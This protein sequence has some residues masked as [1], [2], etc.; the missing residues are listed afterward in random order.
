MSNLRDQVS[1]VIG[2][3]MANE[4][5]FTSLDVSN[6]IKRDYAPHERHRDVA[7]IVREFWASSQFDQSEEDPYYERS[8]I[9][10]TLENGGS[11]QAFLYHA[12]GVNPDSY[13]ARTQVALKPTPAQ[14]PTVQNLFNVA[15]NDLTT[16]SSIPATDSTNSSVPATDSVQTRKQKSDYRLEIP[17]AWVRKLGWNDNDTIYAVAGNRIVLKPTFSVSVDDE[18]ISSVVVSNGRLRVPKSAFDKCGPTTGECEVELQNNS[19]E[20]RW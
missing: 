14:Q 15:I 19:I 6:I 13:D 8:L 16:N 11:A 1:T 10:V 18:V 7:K 9:T 12:E 17:A 5:S 20:I 2:E 3:L 4:E